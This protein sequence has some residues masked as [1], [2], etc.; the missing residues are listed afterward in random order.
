MIRRI[1]LQAPVFQGNTHS[2]KIGTDRRWGNDGCPIAPQMQQR[3]TMVNL[4]PTFEEEI[5]GTMVALING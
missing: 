3:E 5:Q 2:L 1:I 4:I